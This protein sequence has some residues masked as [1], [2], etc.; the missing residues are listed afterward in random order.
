MGAAL[1][2]CHVYPVA[3][4]QD[5]APAAGLPVLALTRIFGRLFEAGEVLKEEIAREGGPTQ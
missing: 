2:G 3:P 4:S 1:R 5:N